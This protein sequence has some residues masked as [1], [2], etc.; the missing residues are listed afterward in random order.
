[1]STFRKSSFDYKFT[2]NFWINLQ[3][4]FDEITW[5]EAILAVKQEVT[6][7]GICVVRVYL[8]ILSIYYASE[9]TSGEWIL[10]GLRTC[11][12]GDTWVEW[13]VDC[14]RRC[15]CIL[16]QSARHPGAQPASH[17]YEWDLPGC[18]SS[19]SLAW[20]GRYGQR[21]GY[22]PFS[23]LSFPP[24]VRK[25]VGTS[26]FSRKPRYPWAHR[27]GRCASFKCYQSIC[28]HDAGHHKPT[29]VDALVGLPGSYAYS[30]R[31]NLSMRPSIHILDAL[32]LLSPE[33]HGLLEP[34]K[35]QFADIGTPGCSDG[36]VLPQAP[37]QPYQLCQ[38]SW[39]RHKNLVQHT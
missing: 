29:L 37:S 1:M 34:Q 20:W 26:R 30:T 21:L 13:L 32:R 11:P 39:A 23:L 25:V 16:H 38:F 27:S 24:I 36:R 7:E 15:R 8:V 12:S 33:V 4:D 2:I 9:R 3:C 28:L 22:R 14:V 19:G 6:E 17:Y 18:Q 5:F 10:E 35:Q 31:P